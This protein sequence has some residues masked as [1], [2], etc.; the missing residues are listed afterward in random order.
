M[1]AYIPIASIITLTPELQD[2]KRLIESDVER[3]RKETRTHSLRLT[4]SSSPP[5][6][7]PSKESMWLLYHTQRCG[8][9]FAR[10]EQKQQQQ[11]QL[12]CETSWST[13]SCPVPPRPVAECHE[14]TFSFLFLHTTLLNNNK[15]PSLIS[16]LSLLSFCL[17][18]SL[19]STFWCCCC[20]SGSSST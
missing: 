16:C 3:G 8:H 6:P 4:S 15:F 1:D 17:F 7:P 18:L 9:V 2:C 14:S 19:V 10:L 13:L 12:I 5:P 11:M 20:R